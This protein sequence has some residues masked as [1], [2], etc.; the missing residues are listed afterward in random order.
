MA[1]RHKGPRKQIAS[2]L[3]PWVRAVMVGLA[4]RH[5]ISVSQYVADLL[6]AHIGRRDLIRDLQQTAIPYLDDLDITV[7][8]ERLIAP[9]VPVD[10]Y[11]IIAAAAARRVISMSQYVAEVCE[12]HSKG[13]EHQ[14][15]QQEVLLLTSA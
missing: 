3:D 9:R 10:V 6:A 15:D 2:L 7:D 13:R 14:P 12:A 8:D 4:E 11:T 5:S 1:Q